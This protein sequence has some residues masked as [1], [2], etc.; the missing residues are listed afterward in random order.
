M[1]GLGQEEFAWGWGGLSK[2]LKREWNRT[3]GRRHKDFKKG[4]KLGQ[5]L[6]TLKRGGGG[7]EP[8][9]VNKKSLTSSN[10]QILLLGIRLKICNR[11]VIICW[12]RLKI[13]KTG[14]EYIKWFG[15]TLVTDLSIVF[16]FLKHD[17][18]KRPTCGTLVT[19]FFL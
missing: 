14:R 16:Y 3:E 15:G 11:K 7:L 13:S 5:G 2:I 19:E 8:D 17:F 18:T 9:V 6:G 4:R 10:E 1:F 12:K